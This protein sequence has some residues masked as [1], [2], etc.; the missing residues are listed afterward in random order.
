MIGKTIRN[1]IDDIYK[2]EY[3]YYSDLS[4]EECRRRLLGSTV[5]HKCSIPLLCF[6]AKYECTPLSDGQLLLVVK[7]YEYGTRAGTEY[8]LTFSSAGAQTKIVAA[9][10]REQY[11]L[12]PLS[13][14]TIVDDLMAE[15]LGAYNTI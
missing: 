15:K 2:N 6:S 1:W 12:T 14:T 11:D 8:L 3:V 5:I 13:P 7:G 10:Q 9:Y 4:A